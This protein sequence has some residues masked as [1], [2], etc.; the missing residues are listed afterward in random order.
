MTL[1]SPYFLPLT[2]SLKGEGKEGKHNS[3][4]RGEVC[5]NLPPMIENIPRYW[6]LY[7]VDK[8]HP[9]GLAPSTTAVQPVEKI[10]AAMET[11]PERQQDKPAPFDAGAW[12]REMNVRVQL[13]RQLGR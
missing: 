10:D 7:L 5:D 11:L 8:F 1:L 3:G 12:A 6:P 13:Y 2:P 9:Q 4:K